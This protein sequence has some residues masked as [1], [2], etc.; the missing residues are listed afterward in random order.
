MT[1]SF[2]SENFDKTHPLIMEALVKAN[3]GFAYSYGKDGETLKAI[4]NFRQWSGTK[5]VDV[6]FCFNGTGANNFALS[7]VTE[8]HQAIYCADISHLYVSESTAT[9]ALTGC[10]LYSIKSVDGKIDLDDLQ[11]KINQQSI[12]H[13]PVPGLVSVSQPTEYGT[14]YNLDE[15]KTISAFCK[16]NQ[17]LLHIDGARIFNVLESLNCSFN[18]IRKAARPDVCTI[19]GTKCGLMFGEAVLFFSPSRFKHLSLYH[20]RSMQLASKNR[21]IAAQY[22]GLFK[23]K[24]WLKIAKHTNK[25][26]NYFETSVSRICKEAILSRV[27]INTVFVK[28]DDKTFQ[29]LS[30]EACFYEWNKCHNETRFTFSFSNTK[31][32]IDAFINTYKKQIT[33]KRKANE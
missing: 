23:K 27:E 9:E 10:R 31:Q 1:P 26:A 17:L 11:Q 5:D 32:E 19:G 28:M 12:I 30:K 15:L 22:N 21:F 20:K 25:L 2:C 24:L 4:E 16:K 6:F 29:Q 13:S 8:K 3:K 7:A 14:V 18:E 33:I